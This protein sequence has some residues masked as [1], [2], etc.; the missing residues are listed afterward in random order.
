MNTDG[1]EGG[2]AVSDHTYMELGGTGAR[3]GGEEGEGG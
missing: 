1:C 3:G 2:V